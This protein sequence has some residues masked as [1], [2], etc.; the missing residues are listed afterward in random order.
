MRPMKLPTTL[1]KHAGHIITMNAIRDIYKNSSLFI[2][3]NRITEINS[4]KKSAD[5]IIDATNKIVVPGFINCHHHMFQCRLRGLPSLQNQKIEKWIQIVCNAT[6]HMN[7][8]NIYNSA[9]SNMAELLL[10]GCTTTTDMLYMFP[11][12]KKGWFEATIQAARDIGIRFHPYRGSMSLGKKDGALFPDSVVQDSDTIAAQSEDVIRT[13][14]DAKA[15]SMLRVGLAPCTIFTNTAENYTHATALS[16]KYAINLQTH[17]SESVYEDEYALEKFGTRPLEYLMNA[18]WSGPRV[19]FT[20]CIN[21]VSDDI[22]VLSKTKTHMV[23]CPISNAR[24]PVGDMGIAPVSEMIQKKV[25]V[26]IG[27]DGSAGN[28]SSNVLEEL[29]WARTL[30]GVR[31]DSTYLKPLD[32]LAMGTINGAKL[33]N[34]E[35]EIGSI[36]VGKAADIAMFDLDQ[37]EYAGYT[38]PLTALVSCQAR[39]ADTVIV[40]GRVVVNNG[41]L[42]SIYENQILDKFSV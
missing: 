41:T 27:V 1:I 17:L 36:E 38:D 15:F 32:V 5:R 24:Q 33:L 12:G 23:H 4:R 18:G 34:W 31:K 9:L 22:R 20:H 28:D 42:M 40:N 16:N 13:Y 35:N 26:A 8:T 29:R 6:R 11:K 10:Y 19:S 7:E 21:V 30:Q 14:H 25:N 39:R 3:G 2:E 37:V